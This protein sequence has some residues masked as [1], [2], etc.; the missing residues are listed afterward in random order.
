MRRPLGRG[1]A[2]ARG[3]GRAR[4]RQIQGNFEYLNEVKR[5]FIGEIMCVVPFRLFRW[6]ALCPT[7]RDSPRPGG[8]R[9]GRPW[10]RWRS[11]L[12][13]ECP[14]SFFHKEESVKKTC[15]ISIYRYT[16]LTG[17]RNETDECESYRRHTLSKTVLPTER[18]TANIMNRGCIP[19]FF[20]KNNRESR[21]NKCIFVELL[22]TF[23]LMIHSSLSVQ[24]RTRNLDGE[25]GGRNSL[26]TVLL[27]IWRLRGRN[28]TEQANEQT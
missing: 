17:D 5:N 23:F 22:S 16:R 11:A 7:V 3:K 4:A 8:A 24:R 18:E 9:P 1:R 21:E 20:L 15:R 14:S 6:S 28:R 10:T 19:T 25:E 12:F 13:G 27:Y 26:Q 2:D